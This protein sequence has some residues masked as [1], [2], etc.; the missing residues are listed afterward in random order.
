MGKSFLNSCNG[1]AF[2]LLIILNFTFDNNQLHAQGFIENQGQYHNQDNLPVP[3]VKYVGKN[4]QGLQIQ[5]RE[6]GFSYELL[7][8]KKEEEG[9]K[10]STIDISRVDINFINPNNNFEIITENGQFNDFT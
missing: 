2:L 10:N 6:K 8:V 9:E 7:G 5:L 1:V 4:N 3:Q